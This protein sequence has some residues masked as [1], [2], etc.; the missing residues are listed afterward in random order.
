MATTQTS[1]GAPSLKA[2][3]E[4]RVI[5]IRAT[6]EN[7]RA[8]AA[9][10]A[11][12]T[13]FCKRHSIAITGACFT[14]HYN[15]DCQSTDVNLEVCLPIAVDATV[16]PPPAADA[17]ADAVWGDIN[18]RI[19]PAV[20]RAVAMTHVGS[21]SGLPA[22]YSTFYSWIKVNQYEPTGCVREVY[23]VMNGTDVS[24]NSYVTELL[25]PIA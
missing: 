25:L 13:A 11:K 22:A 2:I 4:V 8:Q 14:M 24:E 15:K 18:V 12:T 21:Y 9:L 5:S 3:P 17:S 20:E 10:W 7:Y 16:P 19:L 6:L 1:D 23:I